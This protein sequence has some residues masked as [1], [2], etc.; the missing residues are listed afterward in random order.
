MVNRRQ[1]EF[2][3]VAT[4]C[5]LSSNLENKRTSLSDESMKSSTNKA[6]KG[7]KKE[8]CEAV[9]DGAVLIVTRRSKSTPKP[10][11]KATNKSKKSRKPPINSPTPTHS[12]AD[13]SQ[14]WTDDKGRET[15]RQ[16]DS[17]KDASRFIIGGK[18]ANRRRK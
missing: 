1:K 15:L 18:T 16:V 10:Q 9:L 8:V 6:S 5:A 7:K 13:S 14:D 17:A 2:A 11:P 12:R 4:T 3:A